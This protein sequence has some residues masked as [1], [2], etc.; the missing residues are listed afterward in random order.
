MELR[1][2][3]GKDIMLDCNTIEFQANNYSS[4]TY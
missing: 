2:E 1:Y 4:K 3:E